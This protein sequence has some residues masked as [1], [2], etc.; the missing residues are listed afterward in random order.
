MKRFILV[1]LILV[2]IMNF[3]ACKKNE[4][5][6][7][8][9]EES[10]EPVS[11]ILTMDERILRGNISEVFKES[12]GSDVNKFLGTAILNVRPEEYRTSD[13]PIVSEKD[14]N[15][16]LVF[17]LLHLNPSYFEEYAISVSMN[18]T[19]VYTVL[20]VKINPGYEPYFLNS[21]RSR[22]DDLSSVAENYPDQEYILEHMVLETVGQY[23]IL[24]ICDNAEDV[25]KELYP[26]VMDWDLTNIKVVPWLTEEE[27]EVLETDA[28]QNELDEIEADLL[29]IIVTPIGE[30]AE[31][32]EN[33]NVDLEN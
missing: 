20:I 19:R 10:K 12:K 16:D 22:L 5:N 1:F 30:D 26:V 25:F 8:S 7:L 4:E 27:R 9:G 14:K 23:N 29:D 2:C 31:N 6:N 24:I 3:S 18:M 15:A 33:E 11:E 13:I 32:L 21:I 28:L 17:T